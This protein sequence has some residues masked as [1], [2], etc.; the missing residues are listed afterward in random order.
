MSKETCRRLDLG[1]LFYRF[2]I[3]SA[4]KDTEIQQLVR[5]CRKTTVRRNES[6]STK[7]GNIQFVICGS[8]IVE[9]TDKDCTK[10]YWIKR[11]SVGECVDISALLDIRRNA[12]I[13]TRAEKSTEILAIDKTVFLQL[14]LSNAEVVKNIL[15][16]QARCLAEY[17]SQ[18]IIMATMPVMRRLKNYIRQNTVRQGDLLFYDHKYSLAKISC[19]LGASREMVSRCMKQLVDSDQLTYVS[20][21][22]YQVSES[23][24]TSDPD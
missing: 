10:N 14:A 20:K 21:I 5:Y 4:F 19:L 18:R 6:I 23:F 1:D 2:N 22:R 15:T 11:I 8:L 16:E 9:Y 13:N 3:L 12:G 7:S 24:L 17:E